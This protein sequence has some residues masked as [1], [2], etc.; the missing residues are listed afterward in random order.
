[1]TGGFASLQT[2]VHRE[3]KKQTQRHF[4]AEYDS[5][6]VT[7]SLSSAG[8]STRAMYIDAAHGKPRGFLG[9]DAHKSLAGM[10]GII[11]KHRIITGFTKAM[12]VT[13]RIY[14]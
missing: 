14:N 11:D 1:M 9:T 3:H 13:A 2:N 12:T 8:W 7:G 5:L 6:T 4:H 10:S